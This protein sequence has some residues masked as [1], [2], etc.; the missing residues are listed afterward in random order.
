MNGSPLKQISSDNDK[1]FAVITR[2][3]HCGNG[4]FIP[5]MF[6]VYCKDIE[7]AIEVAMGIAAYFLLPATGSPD[8]LPQ[9]Q[10]LPAGFAPAGRIR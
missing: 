2:C 9:A 6:P 3:G 5:I 8:W 4:N 10:C 1:R 7:A